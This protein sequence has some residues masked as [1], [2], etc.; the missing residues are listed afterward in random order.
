MDYNVFFLSL[1]IVKLINRNI[2]DTL[3]HPNGIKYPKTVVLYNKRHDVIYKMKNGQVYK[4][5][6]DNIAN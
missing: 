4:D 5:L 6:R 1:C 2:Y 3:C